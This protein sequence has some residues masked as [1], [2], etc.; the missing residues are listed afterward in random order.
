MM[1]PATL[2]LS[3]V[4]GLF[5]AM[6]IGG[7]RDALG[8]GDDPPVDLVPDAA[9]FSEAGTACG[10]PFATAECAQC[11]SGACCAEAERCAAGACKDFSSCVAACG[12]RNAACATECRLR[13]PTGYREQ[14]AALQSCKTV[15]CAAACP[16]ECGGY[17]YADAKCGACAVKQCCKEAA[18][19]MGNGECAVLA[20]CERDCP[21][22]LKRASCLARCELEHPNGIVD[23]RKFGVCLNSDACIASCITPQW[24]CLEHPTPAPPAPELPIRVTYRFIDYE[25]PTDRVAGLSVKACSPT[26]LDCAVPVAGPALT[27][28]AGEAT[29]DLPNGFNGYAEVTG[30]PYAQVFVHLPKLTKP[31]VAFLGVVKASTF[32]FLANGLLPEGQTLREDRANLLISVIDCDGGPGGGVKFANPPDGSTPFYFDGLFLS[33]AVTMTQA[34]ESIGAYAGFLNVKPGIGL[35]VRATV[36]ENGLS[37]GTSVSARKASVGTSAYNVVLLYAS[38]P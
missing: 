29:L 28:V 31:S 9:V 27:N 21:S 11:I 38:P 14:E 25:S 17:V 3:V 24:A 36:T 13:F 10:V 15:H 2:M 12:P 23:E 4:L 22:G 18:A 30:E 26:R 7:C 1:R 5:L 37:F 35:T 34:N 16:A 33:T 20:A 32:D 19:C 8:I 6:P